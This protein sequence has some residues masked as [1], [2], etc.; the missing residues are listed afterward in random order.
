VE[1]SEVDPHDEAAF[2]AWFGVVHA[3]EQ[4]ERPGEPS[5]LLEEQR[6]QSIGDEDSGRVLLAA[7]DGD[8]VVGAARLELPQKDNP[9]LCEVLLMVHPEHR[10]R[11]VGRALDAEVV[12]RVRADGRTTVLGYG[13]EPPDQTGRSAGRLGSL[14]LGYEVVQTEVRRDIDLPLPAALVADLQERCAPGAEG[15][16]IRSWWDRVPD[17]LVDD[18]AALSAAMST[19]VPKDG[20]DW[21]EEV[22]DAARVRRDEERAAAMDRTYAAA[23]AVERATGRLVAFTTMGLPRSDPRRAYQWETIVARDH[24]GHRLGTLVKL[25]ALQLLG[26]RDPGPRSSAPGTPRRTGR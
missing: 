13:D 11:G 14:G 3:T 18:C 7:R 17:D 16:E 2:T 8:R 12:R 10:R 26:A 1:I 9:H 21:R 22:W 6:V 4:H 25:A 5:W 24:R 20:M 15:Y 23:G 19:D